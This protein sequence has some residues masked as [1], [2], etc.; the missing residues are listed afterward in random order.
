MDRGAW[1]ATVH[2]VT[3]SQTRL[4][5]LAHTVFF[6]LLPQPIMY[7]LLMCSGKAGVDECYILAGAA[8]ILFSFPA[9]LALPP[10]SRWLCLH[11]KGNMRWRQQ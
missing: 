5:D 2:R 10:G 4:S 11:T 9:T 3:K 8:G 6:S 7:S 1:R